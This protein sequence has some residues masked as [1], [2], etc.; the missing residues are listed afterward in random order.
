MNGN[1]NNSNN[2]NFFRRRQIPPAG[3]NNQG[4]V[5]QYEDSVQK[6]RN[7]WYKR[8]TR[9]REFNQ[10]I[11]AIGAA[12]AG[13]PGRQ[14]AEASVNT[15]TGQEMKEAYVEAPTKAQGMKDAA[16]VLKKKQR[17][18]RIIKFA[19]GFCFPLLF[20]LFFSVLFTENADSQIYS[21]E[22]GGTV[23]SDDYIEDDKV[24]NVFANYPGLYETIVEKTNKVS[25]KYKIEVDK[26]LV[27]STLVTP[28]S[29]ELI[30]P[31][32][33]HSCGEE[34]C[35]YFRGESKTWTEFLKAWGDQA[36]LLSKMQIISFTNPESSPSYS[37][38]NNGVIEPNKSNGFE[39]RMYDYEQIAKND[40]SVERAYAFW[41]LNPYRW[42]AGFR[43]ATQAELN[44]VC[45]QTPSG[46]T[47]VPLV[48]TQSI[49]PADY[50]LTNDKD[51][52]YYFEKDNLNGGVY[53]WNL[54][55]K[56]G[57]LYEY[58]KD[59]LTPGD[60]G[61]SED[62]IYE[63]NK[64]KIV[65]LA[66]E[67]YFYYDTIKKSCDGY[68]VLESSIK[69]IKIYNPPEKQS[70]YGVPENQEID[71]EEQYVG[72]VILAEFRSAGNEGLKAF[73]ILVRSEA[74][75]N[76][77]LDGSGT[78][79]NSSNK[80]NYNPTYTPEAYPDIARAVRETRGMVL[81][82][83]KKPDV[84]HTEY[85][86]F[87]PVKNT[88]ENGFYYLPDGQQNIPI[89][90]AK[91]KSITGKE[92]IDPNHK[93]LICPCF[94]SLDGMPSDD[95]GEKRTKYVPSSTT[96]PTE[97]AGEPPQATD[98]SCWKPTN[99][100][101]TGENGETLYGWKYGSLGGHGRGASQYGIKYL[102]AFGYSQDAILRLFF[103]G[104]Q[105][106]ILSS[107]LP[108]NKCSN[109]DYYTGEV[110]EGVSYNSD[111]DENS[112]YT[113]SLGG[114]PLTKPLEQAL[115]DKGHTL[116]D[117]VTCI[118][119]RIE[120]GGPGT[121]EGVVEAG[122]GLIKC[123]YDLTGGYTYPYNHSGG[124]PAN[125]GLNIINPKWGYPGGSCPLGNC[126]LGLNCATFVRTS[127]CNGGMN[128]C[129][130]GSTFAHEMFDKTY[131]PG[132]TKILIA[133]V[134]RKVFGDISV[135][136]GEEVYE[137]IKPGDMLYS[138]HFPRIAEKDHGNHVMLIV[139]KTETALT[140]AENGRDIRSISKKELLS[141]GRLQY[142]VLLL[143]DYY[144]NSSNVR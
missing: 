126:R 44:A 36:E 11:G 50:Y 24:V 71:F 122:V 141:P 140:I 100:T 132:A 119:D 74:I 61:D 49:L 15:K 134:F 43:D 68:R 70:R 55:N 138:E 77:G 65:E 106:R 85:D 116:Q 101:Q 124:S 10:A 48:T 33:D 137:L 90:P 81:S 19:I 35:Y 89:N 39:K 18:K 29:N 23:V 17:R 38:S 108:E 34:N 27:I 87:C 14:I 96:P 21:N 98:A 110:E 73:A 16:E 86:S 136:S 118:Q 127:F 3:N 114:A 121:R 139:G 66:N 102:D 123:T 112:N 20:I 5:N 115:A 99:T 57:F 60:P 30:V 92:F 62:E 54:T 72:G 51:H 78:I 40:L 117:L 84:W 12:V 113:E 95:F 111:Y 75:A 2:N 105:V 93:D 42:F 9:E 64:A 143:D 131:F 94:Q 37:C 83:Y 142:G 88:L 82:H 4:Q 25:D 76:V 7:R 63:K 144:A 133:P 135:S 130:K 32:D 1:N 104:A 109:I 31:V 80:Q 28:I 26:F 103:P 8:K 107:L 53:F 41:W 91:Y 67:I 120:K 45:T 22:N 128:M 69:T 47:K 6:K 13:E 59:Y 125:V 79:E 129:D 52:G 58:L 97:V 46:K 56:N